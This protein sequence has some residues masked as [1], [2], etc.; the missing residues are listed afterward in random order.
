MIARARTIA[1]LAVVAGGALAI[2][3]STQTWLDVTLRTG[4]DEPLTVAGAA[5][6][7]LLA[8]LSLASLALG[9]ALTVVGIALR[10]VFGV[11][12]VAIGAA[13]AVT[14]ARVGLQH[15]LDAVATAVTKTTGLSGDAAVA[16]LVTA[17]AGTPWPFFASAAGLLIAAGGVLTLVTAHRWRAG[18]RRYQRDATPAGAATGSRPHDAIDS[19]DDLT[20]GADPTAR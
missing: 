19:W 12:A 9:L 15:P 10:Y 16:D 20:H 11:L 18:G 14:S 8:P 2:I 6:V 7:P 4:S 1:V 17:V 5:A 3:A 13:L